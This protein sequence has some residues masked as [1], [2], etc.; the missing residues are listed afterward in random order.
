MVVAM[1]TL[2]NFNHISYNALLLAVSLLASLFWFLADRSCL[3]GQ[4][5][6]TP[7]RCY[8]RANT[9]VYDTELVDEAAGLTVQTSCRDGAHLRIGCGKWWRG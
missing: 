7:G 4:C 2:W 1:D 9:C 8:D 6:S 3:C 5:R